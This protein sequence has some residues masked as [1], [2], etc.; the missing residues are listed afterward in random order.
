MLNHPSNLKSKKSWLSYTGYDMTFLY[1]FLILV[2]TRNVHFG[3][4]NQSR[5]SEKQNRKG[6]GACSSF[7]IKC[8]YDS[9]V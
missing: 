5:D 2:K 7:G 4:A 9:C 8:K 1:W 3:L 6:T